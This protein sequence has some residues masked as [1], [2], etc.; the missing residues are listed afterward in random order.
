MTSITIYSVIIILN[1]VKIAMHIRHWTVLFLFSVIGCS[2]VPYLCYIWISN[3]TL[4]KYVQGT[5]RMSFV[6]PTTYL[7]V[8]LV[9]ILCIAI[10][11]LIIYISFHGNKVMKKLRFKMIAL[12]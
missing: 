8:I 1:N 11:S 12:A 5:V 7:V 4:S 2:L 9:T 10:V 3:Y 6:T